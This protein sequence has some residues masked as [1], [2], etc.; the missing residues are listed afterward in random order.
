MPRVRLQLFLFILLSLLLSYLLSQ[1]LSI[2]PSL[3][4]NFDL[5]ITIRSLYIVFYYLHYHLLSLPHITVQFYFLYNYKQTL[6][7]MTEPQPSN[8]H[9]SQQNNEQQT[10]TLQQTTKN[11]QFMFINKNN[12]WQQCD[13]QQNL[14]DK[15]W[16]ITYAPENAHSM[17][18]IHQRVVP[19]TFVSQLS[20]TL[21]GTQHPNPPINPTQ[22]PTPQNPTPSKEQTNP[23]PPHVQTNNTIGSANKNQYNF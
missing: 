1:L 2:I 4:L 21:L 16:T 20:E 10:Q 23:N 19:S 18:H 17:V 15:T 12:T 22:S 6:H 13:A 8:T 3:L 5:I 9:N 7:K 14:L 11:W